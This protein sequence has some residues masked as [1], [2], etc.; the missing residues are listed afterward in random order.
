MVDPISD[1]LTR[2]RNA[3]AVGHKSVD[4]SFSRIKSELADILHSNG[5]IG[6]VSKKGKGKQK[7][8]EIVLKYK[9]GKDKNP[10]IQGLKRISKPGQKFYVNKKKLWQ[11]S[12]ER[13]VVVLSTSQ[14]LMTSKEAKQKGIGGEVL[15]IVW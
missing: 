13:G 7:E 10:F 5:Y 15:C 12:K 3:Q 14:G 9:Y 4:L 1:M 6:N 11:F 2:I 8:I